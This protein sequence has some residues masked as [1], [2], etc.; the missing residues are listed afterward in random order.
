MPEAAADL[1]LIVRAGGALAL[2]SARYWT[3]IAPEA[4]RQMRRWQEAARAIPD[5]DLRALA[6]AKQ[7]EE[8]FNAQ[9]APTFAT[10]APAARRSQVVEA[11]V[12]LQTI[13]DYLDGLTE[14][15]VSNPLRDGRQLFHAFTDAVD[16]RR[17]P[18]HDYY[19]HR[20]HRDDGGYLDALVSTVRASLSQ[21][22]AAVAVADT[23]QT[24]S[25]R[26]AEAQVRAHAVSSQGTEQLES[27]ASAEAVHAELSWREFLAG[28]ASAVIGMH[29]LIA[30]A[31]DPRT[32]QRDAQQVDAL[33]L[34]AGALAT[35][36]DGVADVEVDAHA[37]HRDL[38]YLR[39][40]PDR[41]LLATELVGIARRASRIAR[42]VPHGAH[43]LMT[44]AGV[45]S[46]YTSAPNAR[47]KPMRALVA[48]VQRELQP[49]VAPTLAFM[50]A[51]R[52][53]KQLRE[54]TASW[55][56]RAP[57]T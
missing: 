51:W 13:Y 33:Y 46:Y 41:G 27:W 5:P 31:A 56:H 6:L 24:A 36:L 10:L 42:A 49:L 35:L 47:T 14:Q 3:T 1:G 37:E 54:R 52:L 34:S 28:A 18:R 16:G 15:S 57:K 53:A 48:P 32:T 43:H 8:R 11:I 9:T 21:L 30:A 40:F 2:M 19:R 12:A 39:Y 20:S 7:S 23:M 4:H 29:A 22:P 17:A 38:G 25:E 50:R 44:L 55:T 45:V 26:C